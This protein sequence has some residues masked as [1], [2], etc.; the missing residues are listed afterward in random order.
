MYDY[1]ARFYMP[2]LGRW[3]VVDPLAEQYRRHSTYNYAMNNPIR[4]IDPDGR[5]VV[6]TTSGTTYTGAH[7]QSAFLQLISSMTNSSSSSPDWHKD[8][9]GN[10]VKDKGDNASTLLS[11]VNNNYKDEKLSES[12][13]NTLYSTLED[14]KVDLNQLNPETLNKNLFGYNYPGGKNPRKYNGESDYSVAPTE[15]E[16]PAFIHDKDY[17]K[18][19]AVGVHYLTIRLQL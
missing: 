17:D 4:F 14:G 7:A 16:V 18:L 6:E 1:G 12:A 19:H 2:D 3:G 10:L 11:Y 13:A 8:K 15:I 9:K 5:G